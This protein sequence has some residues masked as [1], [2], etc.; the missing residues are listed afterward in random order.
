MRWENLGFLG[1][2]KKFRVVG[3]RLYIWEM[4]GNEIEKIYDVW[5][6]IEYEEDWR[7]FIY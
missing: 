7:W 4:G 3:N 2:G 6:F 1:R 5:V